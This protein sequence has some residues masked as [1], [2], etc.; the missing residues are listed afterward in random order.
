MD[1]QCPDVERANSSPT[2]SPCYFHSL[3]VSAEDSPLQREDGHNYRQPEKG[4]SM[5][6]QNMGEIAA[7]S[8]AFARS[9]LMEAQASGQLPPRGEAA[10]QLSSKR[11]S[12]EYS[13][14]QGLYEALS[15]QASSQLQVSQPFKMNAG[16]D[17]RKQTHLQLQLQAAASGP[18]G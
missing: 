18:P 14:Q 16:I 6:L 7:L 13:G 12:R 3:C 9:N 1:Y 4:K 5:S 11:N 17:W 15:S 8:N 10:A 2:S